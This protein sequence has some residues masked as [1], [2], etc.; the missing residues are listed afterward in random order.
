MDNCSAQ[1]CWRKRLVGKDRT[2]LFPVHGNPNFSEQCVFVCDCH[3]QTRLGYSGSASTEARSRTRGCLCLLSSLLKLRLM[4]CQYTY[5]W[6]AHST[7]IVVQTASSLLLGNGCCGSV[8]HSN[9][10]AGVWREK[11][12]GSQGCSTEAPLSKS[13]A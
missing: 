5:S 6:S 4:S 10:A 1:E 2:V 9:C 12:S 7:A 13:Q 3:L 11:E 8:S